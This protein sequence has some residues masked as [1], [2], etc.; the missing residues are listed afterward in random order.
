MSIY[1]QAVV[2]GH[3][4]DESNVK[5]VTTSLVGLRDIINKDDL[6]P[7]HYNTIADQLI[8]VETE[9]GLC[10]SLA[11]RAAQPIDLLGLSLKTS[12][13]LDEQHENL[14]VEQ[15]TFLVKLS[16]ML[17]ALAAIS[18]TYTLITTNLMWS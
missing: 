4:V 15:I 16:K 2:G 13:L 12:A 17:T 18:Q 10:G 6:L 3:P 1:F 7:I 11:E 5:I 14:T 9:D 8:Q